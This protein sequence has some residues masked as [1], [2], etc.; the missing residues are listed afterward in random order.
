[1]ISIKTAKLALIAI[2]GSAMIYAAD[3]NLARAGSFSAEANIE[4]VTVVKASATRQLKFNIAVTPH[5]SITVTSS[6]SR[7]GSSVSMKDV[8]QGLYKINSASGQT[9]SVMARDAGN[10][11]G[12]KLKD[13]NAQYGE[14][15]VSKNILD[16]AVANLIA[17]D[18]EDK[19][20][21]VELA[22][23]EI[24][25][26]RIPGGAKELNPEFHLDVS[27]E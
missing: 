1:M 14:S 23:L 24:D 27:Y 5:R 17:P 11:A 2:V 22:M 20:L 8:Q 25:S 4:V 15:G 9:V 6:T 13:I 3:S 12:V 16:S 10:V 21:R 26:T 19:D 18:S 7:N